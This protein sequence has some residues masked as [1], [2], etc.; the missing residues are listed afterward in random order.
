MTAGLETEWDYSGRMERD[1]RARKKMKRVK[2]GKK[3]KVKDIKHRV[4]GGEVKK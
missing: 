3:E 2:N 1:G 4:E